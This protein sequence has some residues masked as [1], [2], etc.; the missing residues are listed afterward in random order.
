[1]PINHLHIIDILEVLQ[2]KLAYIPGG[3]DY[4]GRSVIIVNVPPELQPTTK[5]SLQ[6]VIE[7]F[8]S[9][10]RFVLHSIGFHKFFP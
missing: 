1:M 4:E 9:I 8:L 10:F 5:P 3:R 7:Y 6:C 2:S